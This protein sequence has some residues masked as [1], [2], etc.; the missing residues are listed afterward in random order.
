MA[1]L[2]TRKST[3]RKNG[4]ARRQQLLDAA[5][6]LL[7]THE[8]DAISLGD[9]AAAAEVPKGSAYH[10][11]DDIKDLYSALL[12]RFAEE[13][14]GILEAPLSGK[15]KSWRDV[16]EALNRRGVKFYAGNRAAMQ[17]QIGPKVPTE[18]KL[19]DRQNDAAIGGIYERHI[20]THFTLP[21]FEDRSKVFFRAVEIA[22]L[23]FML[24]VLERGHITVDM[25][26]EASKAMCA[27][28]ACYLPELPP[29]GR[30]K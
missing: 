16:V 8:L 24:S 27:Y 5:Q 23:M 20:A 18:L 3:L 13:L 21:E 10:F 28:L 9:V 11:Y 25:G 4:I 30:T 19:R 29:R 17:L 6:G 14:V 26:R 1:L 2:S 12:S 22:D 15:L 7:E